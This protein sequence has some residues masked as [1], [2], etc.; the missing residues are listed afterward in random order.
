MI[1]YACIYNFVR[2]DHPD[3]IKRRGVGIYYKESLLV[4]IKNLPYFKEA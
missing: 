2:A 3:N 1:L 4:R